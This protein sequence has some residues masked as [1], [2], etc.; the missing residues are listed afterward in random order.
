M[1]AWDKATIYPPRN[2]RKL[3]LPIP[4]PAKAL[5]LVSIQTIY[6]WE[7]LLFCWLDAYQ[8]GLRSVEA[9]LKVKTFSSKR[10]KSHRHILENIA[11]LFDWCM[12]SAVAA[13]GGWPTWPKWFIFLPQFSTNWLTLL[14]ISSKGKNKSFCKRDKKSGF[15][16][17]WQN[18]C[19]N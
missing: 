19:T 14:G 4:Q 3:L 1:A 12:H 15:F 7:H 6:H 18:A 17:R 5:D 10:Y 16:L 8:E 9:Q 2:I 13:V 11:T